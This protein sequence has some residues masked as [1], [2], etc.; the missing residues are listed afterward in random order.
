MSLI[1]CLEAPEGEFLSAGL[2][3]FLLGGV[4]VA[5]VVIFPSLSPLS[6]PLFMY[7]FSHVVQHVCFVFFSASTCFHK[8]NKKNPTKKRPEGRRGV[9]R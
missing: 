5:F 8:E 3:S 4:L 2:R 6:V 1:F 9:G 7:S